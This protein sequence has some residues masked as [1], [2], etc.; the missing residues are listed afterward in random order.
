[1]EIIAS[2]EEAVFI[3]DYEARC[4]LEERKQQNQRVHS[5]LS[6]DAQTVEYEALAH[7]TAVSRACEIKTAEAFNALMQ[8]LSTLR[9]SKFERLQVVNALPRNVIDFY[10]LVEECEERFDTEVIEQTILPTIS[11]IL[12]RSAE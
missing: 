10:V 3:S 5:Q 8:Y 6:Q 2:G 12:E 11:R 1:M 4:L 9:L 7:L